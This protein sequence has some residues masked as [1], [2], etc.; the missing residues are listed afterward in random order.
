MDKFSEAYGVA[1]KLCDKIKL[2]IKSTG[3]KDWHIGVGYRDGLPCACLWYWH[4]EDDESLHDPH[5]M[6]N[7][8]GRVLLEFSGASILSIEKVR[9]MEQYWLTNGG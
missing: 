4:Q 8:G 5:L 6:I 1:E 2:A 9:N 3:A 7:K